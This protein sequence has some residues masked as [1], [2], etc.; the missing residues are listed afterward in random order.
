MSRSGYFAA[1]LQYHLG[2]GPLALAWLEAWLL[3]N[4]DIIDDNPSNGHELTTLVPPHSEGCVTQLTL[5]Y[6]ITCADD[7]EYFE[8]LNEVNVAIYDGGVATADCSSSF[9]SSRPE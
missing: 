1:T 5:E 7:E 6:H 9:S 2:D 8:K 4:E 3:T